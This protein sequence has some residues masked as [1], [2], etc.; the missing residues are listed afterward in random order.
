MSESNGTLI[1][2][3]KDEHKKNEEV[4]SQ[5]ISYRNQIEQLLYLNNQLKSKATVLEQRD[6]TQLQKKDDHTDVNEEVQKLRGT[7]GSSS[8]DVNKGNPGYY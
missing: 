1:I 6:Q 3:Q 8:D 5:N 7:Q 2:K 4:L